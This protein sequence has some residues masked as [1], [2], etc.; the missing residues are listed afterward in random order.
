M[1]KRPPHIWGNICAFHHLLGSPSSYMTWQLVHSEFPIYEEN[2]IFFFISAVNRLNTHT[3]MCPIGLQHS[4]AFSW[5]GLE[6][7][8]KVMC[9]AWKKLLWPCGHKACADCIIFAL[10]SEPCA[11]G[12]ARPLHAGLGL[13]SPAEWYLGCVD[14]ASHA[15]L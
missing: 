10:Y 9:V 7:Q 1:T 4:K 2:L 15:Q 13:Q 5:L 3:C 14:A 11:L 8:E 12:L 6:K